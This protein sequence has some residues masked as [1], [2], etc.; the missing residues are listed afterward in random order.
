MALTRRIARPMLAAIFIAE[1]IDALRDPEHKA[2]AAQAV[3]VPLVEWMP[4]LPDDPELLVRVNG[5]V[6]VGAGVLLA[7]GRF[8]RLA[9]VALIGSIIPTTYA[10]HRFWEEEEGA[11]RSEQQMHFLKN[12]GL[13][14]GLILAA[15]DT[16]G[17]PSV[18]WRARRRAAR[19]GAALAIGRAAGSSS[20]RH[21]GNSVAEGASAFARHAKGAAIGVGGQLDN[22][23]SQTARHAL[24]GAARATRHADVTAAHLVDTLPGAAQQLAEAVTRVGQRAADP[25]SQTAASGAEAVAPYLAAGAARAGNLVDRA[26]DLLER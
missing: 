9:S 20:A 24:D 11:A 1:G 22:G 26:Q 10:G 3:T 14:G 23:A 7:T 13:L 25:V 8:R 18:G 21:T 2:K 15:F 19:V 6:Q 5:A 17:K 12:L 4:S 16:E